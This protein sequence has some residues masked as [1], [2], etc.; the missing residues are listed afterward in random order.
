M[1]DAR[2]L[3][4]WSHDRTDHGRSPAGKVA[5]IFVWLLGHERGQVGSMHKLIRDRKRFLGCKWLLWD[6]VGSI[7]GITTSASA[8]SC[9]WVY[10]RVCVWRDVMCYVTTQADSAIRAHIAAAFPR[11]ALISEE[12]YCDSVPLPTSGR[13]WMVDPLDGACSFTERSL[14]KWVVVR[15]FATAVRFKVVAVLD[16]RLAAIG[17]Q[18]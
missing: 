6:V 10:L 11:D 16:D 5:R 15:R 18:A 4:C 14:L 2:I 13:V 12:T 17:V 7:I 3:S 1:S 8:T 9:L